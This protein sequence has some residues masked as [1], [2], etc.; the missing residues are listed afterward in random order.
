MRDFNRTSDELSAERTKKAL[1]EFLRPEFL[2]RVDEIITFR[3]LPMEVFPDIV[4]LALDELA[5]GLREREIGFECTEQAVQ[6]L[7][8][9]SYSAEYGARNVRRVV[10]TE[11]E[12]RAVRIL[13]ETFEIPKSVCVS[14][15]EGGIH[16]SLESQ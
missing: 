13:C 4:R 6:L 15:S 11:I 12:D 2:N 8:E 10:Q 7:A 1:S 14:V 9:K 16:V 3:S 5:A